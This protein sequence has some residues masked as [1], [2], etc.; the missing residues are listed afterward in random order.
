MV[1]K[2]CFPY[3]SADRLTDINSTQKNLRT[4]YFCAF[5]SFSSINSVP[6]IRKEDVKDKSIS[7]AIVYAPL[8]ARTSAQNE[9]IA[10]LMSR[11]LG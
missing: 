5:Y 7:S 3:V 1:V 10:F 2:L 6:D 11:I 8:S 9:A 4:S